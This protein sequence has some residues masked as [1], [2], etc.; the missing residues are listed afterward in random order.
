MYDSEV[1]HLS[2][3]AIVLS[4]CPHDDI[5]I[6]EQQIWCIHYLALLGRLLRV[7]LMKWVSNA[8]LSVRPQKVSLISVKFGM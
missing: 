7:D 8:C 2:Y 4:F 1:M 5:L 3:A 6:S